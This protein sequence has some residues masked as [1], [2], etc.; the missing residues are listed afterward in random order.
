MG[1]VGDGVGIADLEWLQ[2]S[3]RSLHQINL[4]LEIMAE[5]YVNL[6]FIGDGHIH[7]VA[8]GGGGGGLI[9]HSKEGVHLDMALETG[10][11]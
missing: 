7:V 5:F 11:P 10:W 2:D 4:K 6:S 3:K 8:F 1:P 9:I